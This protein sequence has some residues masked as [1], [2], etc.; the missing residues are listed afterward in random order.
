MGTFTSQILVGKSHPNDGGISGI[1]HTLYLWENSIPSWRL[2]VVDGEQNKFVWTPTLEYILE[3]ALLMIALYVI[4][5]EE[6]IKYCNSILK[7]EP[8]RLMLYEDFSPQDLNKLRSL[9]KKAHLNG[10]I[11]ISVFNKSSVLR[12]LPVL[13]EYDMD[14]EVCV[15]QYVN[16]YSMWTQMREE[17]GKLEEVSRLML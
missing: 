12:H 17:R 13:K 1:T 8:N 11:M 2:S 4:E 6:T 9:V 3:D 7:K 14:V 5:D 16:E 10:K 15:S